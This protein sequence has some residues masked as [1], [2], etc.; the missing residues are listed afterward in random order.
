MLLYIVGKNGLTPVSQ[1]TSSYVPPKQPIYSLS[2]ANSGVN[3][4]SIGSTAGN[5]VRT[6]SPI[7]YTPASGTN[8]PNSGEGANEEVIMSRRRSAKIEQCT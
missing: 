8:S 1:P 7:P 6:T 5:S 4:V 3:A 2:R